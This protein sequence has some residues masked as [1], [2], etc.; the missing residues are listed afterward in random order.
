MDGCVRSGQLANAD[1][2]LIA[3]CVVLFVSNN[4]WGGNAEEG[5][6]GGD[7]DGNGAG[8]GARGKN[9]K[10]SRQC[11]EPGMNR[12]RRQARRPH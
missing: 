6:G 10:T 8:A 5:K 1:H 2:L 12:R 7:G 4:G 11:H 9:A 3:C